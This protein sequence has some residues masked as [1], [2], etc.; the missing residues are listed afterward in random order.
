MF[1]LNLNKILLFLNVAV[2]ITIV[3]IIAAIC[4]KAWTNPTGDPPTGSG[5]LYYSNGN[6][7]IGTTTP[8]VALE[9]NGSVRAT[10]LQAD[11]NAYYQIQSSDPVLGFDSNDYLSYSRASNYLSLAIGGSEKLRVNSSGYVGI[12]TTTPAV[13]L[14]VVG[15]LNVSGQING[16]HGQKNCSWSSEIR[17]GEN[18]TL[19]CP[20]GYYV[21]AFRGRYESSYDYYSIYCC[22]F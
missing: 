15:D 20:S 11:A 12:G 21:A 4:V 3:V 14:S 5:A 8:A 16:S 17:E 6:V 7:G 22:Q 18:A 2:I 10:S 13:A 1:K 9:V 19:S